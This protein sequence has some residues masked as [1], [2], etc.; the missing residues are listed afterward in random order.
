MAGAQ[1]IENVRAVFSPKN[2]VTLQAV[3]E[4]FFQD[5]DAA[6]PSFAGHMLVS[7]YGFDEPWPTW[8]IHPKGDEL[9]LL[10]SGDTDLVLANEDGSAG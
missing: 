10:L 5:L 8:E 1:N 9:V 2:M 7:Q 6:F 4:S 3:T